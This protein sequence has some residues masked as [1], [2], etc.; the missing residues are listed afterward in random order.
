[1]NTGDL[2]RCWD[3]NG[4]S[5]SLIGLVLEYDKINKIATVCF[6]QTGEVKRIAARDLELFR[7]SPVNIRKLKEKFLKDKEKT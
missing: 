4:M 5:Y 1:M 3:F 2:V 6:Q 7:R